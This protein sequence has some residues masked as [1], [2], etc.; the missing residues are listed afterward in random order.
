MSVVYKLKVNKVDYHSD[1]EPLLPELAVMLL[2]LA[3]ETAIF[4]GAMALFNFGLR[5]FRLASVGAGAADV[6]VASDQ[7]VSA[8]PPPLTTGYVP[9]TMAVTCLSVAALLRAPLFYDC[10]ICYRITSGPALIG[11][12]IADV[13]LLVTW[14]VVWLTITLKQKWSFRLRR[15][16][17]AA[18]GS[19]KQRVTFEST[20]PAPRLTPTPKN[21][22]RPRSKRVESEAGVDSSPIRLEGGN[23]LFR[24][25]SRDSPP[26]PLTDDLYRNELRNFCDSYYRSA[27]SPV[28]RSPRSTSSADVYRTTTAAFTYDNRSRPLSTGYLTNVG[29]RTE[30]LVTFPEEPWQ[31]DTTSLDSNDVLCS[32]V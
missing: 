11:S 24:L 14:V 5:Q 10:V 2:Y 17:C 13:V 15:C 28:A 30:P 8:E 9:H 21:A 27:F 16:R 25:T 7:A 26:R 32:R 12:A 3:A 31:Y 4:V 29:M 6:R 23:G 19:C 18:D 1:Y 20:T 22:A